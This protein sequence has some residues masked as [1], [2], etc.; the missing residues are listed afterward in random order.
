MARTFT[1]VSSAPMSRPAWVAVALLLLGLVAFITTAHAGYR[2][3]RDV[4]AALEAR[5]QAQNTQ[6]LIERT[7]S[8]LL[9]LETGQRGFIITGQEEFLE[10]YEVARLQ[11]LA[12]MAR[13]QA[14]LAASGEA[15]LARSLDGMVEQRLSQLEVI[16]DRRRF[17]GSEVLQDLAVYAE[18]KHLMDQIRREFARLQSAQQATI[19][20]RHAEVAAVQQR[21]GRVVTA[22]PAVGCAMILLALGLLIHERRERSR[23]ERAL[24]A[25]NA[26]LEGRVER[27]TEALRQALARIQS[28]ASE[29]DRGIEAERRRLARDVHDQFGQ[30]ATAIK[31][32]VIGLRQADPPLAE[33][34]VIQLIELVD[35]AIVLAR[36][37][38]ST[39]RPPLL[40]DLGLAAAL[41][42][43]ARDIERLNGLVIDV[44]VQ[45]DEALSADQAN[46]VFRI[47]QEAVTNV[48][49]HAH[50]SVVRLHGRRSG[51][52]FELRV[53]DDGLGPGPVRPDASGLRNMKERALLAGG[54]LQ[55]GPAGARG[56]EVL[57][58]LPCPGVPQEAAAPR[59]LEDPSP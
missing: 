10:P 55:F 38:A 35:S 16:I 52:R 25:A 41:E 48:L 33:H 42:H 1:D 14:G 17:S 57:V 39:L 58:V 24:I 34:R 5:A 49:R 30:V 7:F 36:R 28:F 50:A 44:D 56:S 8:L 19:Q 26:S 40:D 51:D 4:V 22:L 54:T 6:L 15:D 59:A 21:A 27:R 46:Q 43:H 23:A 11:V 9:D 45:G 20:R 31:M 18:G 12:S 47:V 13:L 2:S 29:L 53:T 3:L 37:I 32:N